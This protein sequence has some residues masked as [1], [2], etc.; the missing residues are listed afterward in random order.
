MRTG[1]SD[2]ISKASPI[3]VAI[4]GGGVGGLISARALQKKGMDVVV[5]EKTSQFKRFGGPIQLAS[6]ALST[7][8]AI[9]SQIF[10]DIMQKFTFT[11]VRTNGIK[12]GIRTEWYTKFDAITIAADEGNLPYTGVIDRPDLQEIMLK[13]LGPCVR[14]SAKVVRYENLEAG[15]VKVFLEDGT[16]EEAD[17]LIGADGIWSNIRAQMWNE[18]VKEGSGAKYSGYTVFAGYTVL[19][20][21][22][23]WDVGYKVYIGPGQYFVISDVGRGTMQWYAF[24]ALPPGTKSRAS[25][26]AYLSDIFKGWS[27]EVHELLEATDENEIEQRDL[28]DRPPQLL[29]SWADGCTALLGDACHPM[30]PNLGQ[31]GC[32]AME[33][34][35]VLANILSELTSRSS[36]PSALQKYY[37]D[38]IVRTSIV[39]GLSRLASDLIVNQFD[40]PCKVISLLPPKIEN[41]GI[42]SVMTNLMRPAMPLIFYAQF[43]YL[44]TFAPVRLAEEE[45]KRLVE[46][47]RKRARV[48]AQAAWNA[49][50]SGIYGQQ[51]K[52]FAGKDSVQ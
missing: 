41:F 39:Q 13:Y 30:M 16:T 9:D 36:I 2:E 5:L 21:D 32:Q 1:V 44:Y 50:A 27:H 37:R 3:K 42:K 51:V 24:L 10:E 33:D 18:P 20:V 14:N 46:T 17:I 35:F 52:Q 6:N 11:G 7:L 26:K 34:G 45:R 29:R 8:K 40:T 4:A 28:F 48:L 25:N 38:R 49:R 31:G 19:E 15:G 23:Y 47:E 12:D 43:K 22:D